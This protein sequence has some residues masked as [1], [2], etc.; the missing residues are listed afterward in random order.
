MKPILVT[1]GAGFIGS[2]VTEA[3]VCRGARVRVLD[4]F[5][6]G[7]AVNLDAV[8][9]VIEIVEGD[10]RDVDFVARQMNGVEKVVHLAAHSGVQP[11]IQSPHL[12]NEINVTGSLNVLIAAQ[13]A[14]IRRVV[15]ASSAS[16]YGN[17]TL[18]PTPED[19]PLAPLSPYG[20]SKAAMEHYGTSFSAVYDMAVISLRF[21]NVYGLRQSPNSDYAAVIPAFFERVRNGEVP[22]VYG[23]GLQSRDFVH[24][25]DVAAA[26]VAALDAPDHVTGVF[27]VGSGIEATLLDLAHYISPTSVPLHLQPKIGD[28][29]H[30]C[31]VIKNAAEVLQWQANVTLGEG[32]ASMRLKTITI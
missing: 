7:S 29:R 23:D 1:G 13:Q 18:V 6:T 28:I 21:F 2:Y 12:T 30:S 14:G 20:A 3:L 16:V 17:P 15:F 25:S 27:N 10:L 32:I 11:S 19:A 5:S 22:H 9:E 24:V 4:N 8:H 31:A 26:V